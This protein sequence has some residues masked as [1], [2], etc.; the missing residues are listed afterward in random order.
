VAK[1]KNATTGRDTLGDIA[2]DLGSLLGSAQKQWRALQGPR[3]AVV[4]AITDVRDRAAALLSEMS[5]AGDEATGTKSNK[6]KKS[7]KD[8]KD[9]SKKD[10]KDRK[11]K[12]SKKDKSPKAAN[13]TRGNAEEATKKPKKKAGRKAGL[14]KRSRTRTTAPA[15]AVTQAEPSAAAP[16]TAG[17]GPEAVDTTAS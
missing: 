11:D 10:K 12:K 16:D 3:D 4:K 5:A 17:A 1:R 14:N 2:E 15:A 9:K 7:K 6:G 8:K 13:A